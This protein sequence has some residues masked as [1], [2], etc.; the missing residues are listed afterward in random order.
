MDSER[1]QDFV[2]NLLGYIIEKP[3]TRWPDEDELH[4]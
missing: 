3:L 1:W 4:A 2:Y